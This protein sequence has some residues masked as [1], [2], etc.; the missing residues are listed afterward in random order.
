[1]KT[2]K[3]ILT[4]SRGFRFSS[5]YFCR[6]ELVPDVHILRP[7]LIRLYAPPSWISQ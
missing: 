7:Q 1:M 5:S 2:L 3:V 4:L 6:S